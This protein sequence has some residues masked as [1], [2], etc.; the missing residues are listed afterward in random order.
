MTRPARP[1][2]ARHLRPPMGW[3]SWDCYGTTVT[4]E[5]VLANAAFLRDHLLA[6]G[7]DTVVVDIQWYEPT[8]RAHGYNPDP[9][10]PCTGSAG[11]G[12]ARRA[13][14]REHGV[15]GVVQVAAA[16][17]AIRVEV[18]AAAPPDV[19]GRVEPVHG[20][21][22]GAPGAVPSSAAGHPPALREDPGADAFDPV[23][24]AGELVQVI[25]AGEVVG[26]VVEPAEGDQRQ[27]SAQLGAQLGDLGAAGPV[28]QGT[29]PVVGGADSSTPPPPAPPRAGEGPAGPSRSWARTGTV[30]T[31]HPW[32][33]LR[34][35]AAGRRRCPGPAGS[36]ARTSRRSD[37]V[38]RSGSVAVWGLTRS[39][40]ARR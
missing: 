30:C 20:D 17:G 40:G 8:A 22:S 37:T 2:P 12:R 13:E 1:I 27:R 16:V 7:W 18:D 14:E 10:R 39:P 29:V 34:A 11:S 32:P 36:S 26:A 38:C 21:L 24:G 4:E 23:V 31:P 33:G 5:E 19:D 35:V 15:G 6:Y 28:V 9:A 25:G 3:N